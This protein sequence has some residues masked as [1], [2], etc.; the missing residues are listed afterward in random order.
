LLR[1]GKL[2]KTTAVEAEHVLANNT[3]DQLIFDPTHTARPGHPSLVTCL[4]FAVATL[5][6]PQVIGL[7]S[8]L[9]L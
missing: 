9:S 2:R 3:L 1:R 4:I 7:I 8:I 6:L 5:A